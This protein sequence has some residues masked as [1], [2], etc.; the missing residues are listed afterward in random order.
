MKSRFEAFQGCIL[1]GAI[2]D[3]LGSSFE[4]QILDQ[5]LSLS[6]AEW[7]LTDDTQLTLATCES[8]LN[9]GTASP[10][11]IAATFAK[12]FNQRKISGIGSSTLKALKE[13]SMGGHWALVGRKGEHAAGN[14]AAMRIAPLAF[15]L[16]PENPGDRQT[17]RD[18]CRITHHNEE[19]YCGALAILFA[20]RYFLDSV[21]PD[22]AS[23]FSYITEHLPDSNTRDNLVKISKSPHLSISEVASEVGSSG[24]VA[25]SV[26]LAVFA[27]SKII[28]QSFA[29]I[30][31]DIIVAGGDT[32]TNC[33]MAGQI[34]GTYLGKE[35]L[36]KELVRPLMD[37]AEYQEIAA[38]FGRYSLS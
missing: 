23:F 11:D 4:N 18:I 10:S 14:G 33:S 21:V 29:S 2:G 7:M 5:P 8:I 35:R 20:I 30:L 38:I 37:L 16:N 13:L 9:S 22:Q 28:E 6:D 17:I 19:A 25:E 34:M 31:E 24:Y 32:D 36:P 3:A 15:V 12:W 1:G 26:P 27:A